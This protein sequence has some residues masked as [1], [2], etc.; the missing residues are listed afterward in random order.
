MIEFGGERQIAV[1]D[2]CKL[3]ISRGGE[4]DA[5]AHCGVET[6]LGLPND[7]CVVVASPLRDNFVVAHDE[8]VEVGRGVDHAIGTIFC[9]DDSLGWCQ[10][11]R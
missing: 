9:Q 2:D 8:H 4:L 7:C 10:Q 5:F 11:I 6:D 1:G 3:L